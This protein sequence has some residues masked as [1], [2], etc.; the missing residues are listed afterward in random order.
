LFARDRCHTTQRSFFFKLNAKYHPALFWFAVLTAVM[1]FLLIGLG[2]LVTSHEAG[3]SV[4]DW[5]T[6][7][8]YNMFALPIKFW[9]GGVFY[10]HTHRLLASFI[11][12]LTTVLA[13]WLWLKDARQWMHWLGVATFFAVVLQGALGGLRVVLTDA[14]LGIFHGAL[15]QLFLVLV[16]AIALFTS[17]W[18]QNS[19][20][21]KQISVPRGLR[22]HVLYVT[23]LIFIQLMIG[24]T[25][26]HQHA[27][28]AIPD[29]PLAYGKIWPDTSA[30]AVAAYNEHRME[31]NGENP[32]TAFQI[33]LQMVHRL[34][35]LLIFLGVIAAAFLA[36]KKLDGRDW[37]TKFAWFW[38]ALIVA[39]IA[40]GIATIETNKAADIA[41]LHVMVGALSLLAGVLWWLVAARRTTL[42]EF[43][44]AGQN[45]LN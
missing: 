42:T 2:G 41:T 7:Y 15:A 13:V 45:G 29:F 3:M 14:Q 19:A 23:I 17:R 1:T 33:I 32:I 39:Q 12:F 40:L 18:W 5:P 31:L 6:S 10:E 16:C 25:M 27:G 4:P 37:L 26:R 11:G 30:E 34:V 8:G 24:A 44:P 35:A 20:A 43:V 38:T 21:E 9:K 28:L 36:R 22:S